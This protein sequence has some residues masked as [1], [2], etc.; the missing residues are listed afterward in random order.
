MFLKPNHC[1]SSKLN[2]TKIH[3]RNHKF[4]VMDFGNENA[5]YKSM[6][7]KIYEINFMYMPLISIY[8]TFLLFLGHHI[9]EEQIQIASMFLGHHIYMYT[10]SP[11]EEEQNVF[12]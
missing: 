2:I 8:Y 4:Y 12:E 1:Q 7:F 10:H 3:Q 9:Y 6:I 5:F 11:Y